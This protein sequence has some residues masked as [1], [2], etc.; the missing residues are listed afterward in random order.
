MFKKKFLSLLN[1][2][3][4]KRIS[5]VAGAW[6][7]YFVSA[8]VPL[9]FLFIT[10]YG[11]FGVDVSKDLVS[12]LPEQFREN[13]YLLVETANRASGKVTVFFVFTTLFSSSALI[14][15]M[16]KD[17][18]R[19]YGVERKGK[20]VKRIV[21]GVFA[22]C[23]LFFVFML[24]ALLI[25][26]GKH[27]LNT[28]FHGEKKGLIT[29]LTAVSFTLISYAVIVLLNLFICPIDTKKSV[30]LFC[31]LISL[32]L[33]FL[34]TMALKFYVEFFSRY[35]R[36]Y[37]GLAGAIGLLTWT[38]WCMLGLVVGVVC[39]EFITRKKLL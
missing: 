36:F 31:S 4:E 25:L 37:G 16:L 11:V 29:V 28:V 3:E 19:I 23:V 32:A 30:V 24:C 17:G 26:F 22:V 39:S 14:R 35:N 38:Y 9:T 6:V 8:I 2:A 15:Q 33:V 21:E 18:S 13:A 5:T 1:Y 7:F 12:R 27:L 20:G 10:A 34:G